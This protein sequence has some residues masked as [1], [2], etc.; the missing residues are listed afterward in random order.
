[1]L[2]G[3]RQ[4]IKIITN[5]YIYFTKGYRE[6]IIQGGNNYGST[7]LDTD[8]ECKYELNILG[9]KFRII[10][11]PRYELEAFYRNYTSFDFEGDTLTI[12]DFVYNK[13]SNN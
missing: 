8:Y 1:M 11:E 3:N 13:V 5:K 12:G 9:N 2:P 7:S 6:D 4:H 10:V